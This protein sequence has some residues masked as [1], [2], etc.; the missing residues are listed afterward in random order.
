MVLGGEN[1]FL[2]QMVRDGVSQPLDGARCPLGW[3]R[4]TFLAKSLVHRRAPLGDGRRQD[5]QPQNCVMVGAPD[6][7]LSHGPARTR[8]RPPSSDRTGGLRPEA[9]VLRPRS[10]LGSKGARQDGPS[11]PSK[12]S[13]GALPRCRERATASTHVSPF[14]RALTNSP[15]SRRGRG[16]VSNTPPLTLQCLAAPPVGAPQGGA[17]W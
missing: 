9:G 4:T 3:S 7:H 1:L 11:S 17:W 15:N 2:L 10:T 12:P 8:P 14:P 16:G 5:A 13:P 6:A